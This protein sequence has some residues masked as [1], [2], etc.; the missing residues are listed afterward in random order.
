MVHISKTTKDTT[1]AEE[2]ELFFSLN[3]T[4]TK[5]LS[6]GQISSKMTWPRKV[7]LSADQRMGMEN[8]YHDR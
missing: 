5:F 6:Q 7:R 2:I 4:N 3:G 1:L 8:N